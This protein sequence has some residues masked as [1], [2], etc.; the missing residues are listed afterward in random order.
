MKIRFKGK[1]KLIP[2]LIIAAA[3]FGLG[4]FFE[5][6]HDESFVVETLYNTEPPEKTAAAAEMQPQQTEREYAEQTES[7]LEPQFTEAPE[8]V[9]DG[10]ININTA[11]AEI[12]DKL[13]GI[14]PSLAQRIIDYR[15]ANG[16]FE[17]V[18]EI[19]Q[20]SGIGEKKLEAIRDKICVE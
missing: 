6:I 2:L 3:T 16:A 12:L 11:D 15:T 9:T 1:A 14:G 13:D 7:A 18:D 19:T 4:L 10:K 5:S 20:V 17:S 8:Q